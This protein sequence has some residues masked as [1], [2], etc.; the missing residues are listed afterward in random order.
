MVEMVDLRIVKRTG[1]VVAFDPVRI[2][3]AIDKAVR[4][5]GRELPVGSLDGLVNSISEEVRGRFLDFYPNV[6][7]VQDIVEKHLL[8]EQLFDIGKAYILYRADRQKERLLAQE[9]AVESAHLGRLTVTKRDGRTQLLNV[10]TIEE[11]VRR[12]ALG[13]SGQI[14]ADEVAREVVKNVYDTVET[15]KID[16]ALVLASASFIERDP[17]YSFVAA[18]LLLQRIYKDVMGS[19]IRGQELDDAY[20]RIFVA[21]IHRNVEHG[22]LDARLA[23]MDLERLSSALRPERDQLFQYLGIQ[24]LSER[25]FLRADELVTEL[26]QG[27]W[28]RV[29]MG[30]AIEEEQSE[31]WAIEFYELMSRLRYIPST[32][33]LFHA[34]TT[35]PQLSSCYLT[36]VEDDL[37]HIFKC[38]GDNSQLSKW[39][40]GIGNDW[41]NIRGT[42]SPIKS[43]N[44]E[45][46]G[47]IPFLKIAN[48]VTMAINR[49]GKRRGATCAYLES[50]H[51]DIEDFLDLRKNTGDERR[52]THDMNTANWIPD[53]FMKRVAAGGSWTLFSPHEVPDLHHLFGRAFEERYEEYEAMARRGEIRL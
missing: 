40:G 9:R 37:G 21:S 3:G 43:T 6:E 5:A 4:A 48:D 16:R 42:G 38:F 39:S 30:L 18:R 34:G 47:V 33:T 8:R 36:T 35:H 53:L 31:D 22:H 23:Q 41:S 2:R 11:A 19:S 49:S 7:N 52:R 51:Y 20:R 45:S 46:Q 32:P 44:V 50:W 13:L 10:K 26:P 25:Y 29:A 17:S 12:A 14:E 27:F 24:T 28:M 1:E 15:E